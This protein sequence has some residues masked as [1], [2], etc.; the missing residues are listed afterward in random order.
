[1]YTKLL[2]HLENDF[3]ASKIKS[4]IFGAMMEVQISNDGPVTI[5]IDSKKSS[6]QE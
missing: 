2:K 1:M 5:Q 6:N 3:D 4:G